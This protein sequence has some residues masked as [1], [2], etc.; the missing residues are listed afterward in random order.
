MNGERAVTSCARDSLSAPRLLPRRAR[1]RL[2]VMADAADALDPIG[3]RRA[4]GDTARLD[5]GLCRVQLPGREALTKA[6]DVLADA[7]LG[8]PPD[9]ELAGAWA[10]LGQGWAT[11]SHAEAARRIALGQ[12]P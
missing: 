11:F 9:G 1:R 2:L 4:R 6:A 8:R 12:A 3:G 7:V 10:A 5:S